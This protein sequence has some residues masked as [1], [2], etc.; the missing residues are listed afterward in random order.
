MTFTHALGTDN[1]GPAKFIVSPNVYEATHTTIQAAITAASAGDTVFIRAKSTAY[2]ENLTLSAGVNLCAF[3][4]DPYTPN[5]TILGTLTATFA[6][7]ATIS[8]INLQT[9]SASILSITG[10]SNTI[11]N[12]INCNFSITTANTGISSITSGTGSIIR[13]LY[14]RGDIG[15]ATNFFSLA[16]GSIQ[17][18][19][20][21]I[22]NS[23]SSTTRSLIQ[24]DAGVTF[25]NSYFQNGITTSE[26]S[27]FSASNSFFDLAF[28]DGITLNGTGNN[29]LNSC[30]LDI[31]SSSL[32][33]G[34]GA[35]LLL[36][37][38]AIRCSN[39]NAI[40]GAGTLNY[41]GVAFY[42]TSSKINTTTQVGGIAQGG[43][44]QAPSAG[45]IGEQLRATGTSVSLSTTVQTNICSISLTAGI[46]NLTGVCALIGALTGTGWVLSINSTSATLSGADGD[47]QVTSPTVSTSNAHTSLVVPPFQVVLTTTTTYYLVAQAVFS[48]GTAT[49][50]GRFTATRIG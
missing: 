38:C 7:T 43:L 2:T 26:T 27:G 35:T 12:F 32:S 13:L 16:H 46:W 24:N 8:G 49:A 31:S 45:F 17:I 14:C 9:N 48:V 4:C 3:A 18:E 42:G 19:Y 22:T 28:G 1:Y 36:S 34:T 40:T 15:A 11:I 6:G 29:R 25:Q 37:S 47:T 30:N 50:T 10:S 20:S 21:F 39:T 41:S 5:V 33:I 44:T 23:N